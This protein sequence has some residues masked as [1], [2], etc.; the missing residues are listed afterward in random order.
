M[1]EHSI[2]NYAS[3]D[4]LVQFMCDTAVQVYLK[5]LVRTPFPQGQLKVQS[6]G[7]IHPPN[8]VSVSCVELL[9]HCLYRLL[10]S[11]LPESS[12]CLSSRPV[13]TA[14]EGPGV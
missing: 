2:T 13:V 12:P 5:V 9:L 1:L 3:S 8:K 11:H 6:H 7:R 14:A 4:A 10:I